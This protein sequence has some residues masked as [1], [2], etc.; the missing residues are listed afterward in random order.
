MTVSNYRPAE[1][2]MYDVYSFQD[3]ALTW[4]NTQI[5]AR[6]ED[7]AY[8]LTWNELKELLLREYCPRSEI[9]KI[10]YEF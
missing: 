9:Q 5:Q 10:E 6:G 8:G 3:E 4:W 7:A 1:R 2:V